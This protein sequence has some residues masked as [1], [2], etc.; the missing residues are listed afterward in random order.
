VAESSGQ[1]YE[2]LETVSS[3]VCCTR[4]DTARINSTSSR[5]NGKP[6]DGRGFGLTE[7]LTWQM[8]GGTDEKHRKKIPVRIA[9]VPD[10]I[11]IR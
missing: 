7:V 8:P 5:R 1:V 10:E 4:Y 6:V 2:S 11:T 3:F 9:G